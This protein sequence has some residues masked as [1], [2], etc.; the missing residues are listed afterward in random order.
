MKKKL[1]CL[2][3]PVLILLSETG[4]SSRK[5]YFGLEKPGQS[6]QIFAP[7]IIST[8]LHNHSS[9]AFSPDKNEVFYSIASYF[10]HVILYKVRVKGM[11]QPPTVASFSGQYYDDDPFF[12]PD[13]N[14]LYFTSK[15]PHQAE[16]PPRKD[17]DIWYVERMGNGWGHPQLLPAAVNKPDSDEG[18]PSLSAAG[19]L[20]FHS[21]RKGSEG[22][23]DIYMSEWKEGK[24]L[25]A[26]NLGSEV[27]SPY[28]D[29]WPCI[30]PDES[31]I[32][33]NIYSEG[34]GPDG[35]CVSFRSEEGIFGKPV[36][37]E[38]L[39]NSTRMPIFS[40]DGELLF[41]NIQGF[42]IRNAYYSKKRLD[43]KTMKKKMTSWENG[44]GNVVWLKADFLQ[45]FKK[46]RL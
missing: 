36:V 27:N 18:Y 19:N 38:E 46:K 34:K 12:S 2:F 42:G 32:V 13:G 10:Y 16:G 20:Y 11:W 28:Q 15:R 23:M 6:P 3:F 25:E 37:I 4:C 45:K 43:Y 17:S 1:L 29:A 26:V 31:L 33:F 41:L 5:E 9:T 14:R 40:H 44:Q 30:S 39:D 21:Y 7:G 24:F 8:D 35:F 22:S